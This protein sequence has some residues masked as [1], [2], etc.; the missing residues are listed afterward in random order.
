MLNRRLYSTRD[1]RHQE[2]YCCRWTRV[3]CDQTG[4]VT[5]LDL[6]FVG[7]CTNELNANSF[8]SSISSSLIYLL[9]LE[10]LDLRYN[11]FSV[12]IPSFIG[13]LT[14]FVLFTLIL[15]RQIF[16][17]RFQMNFEI[18]PR[19]IILISAPI[20]LIRVPF[21]ILLLPSPC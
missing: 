18:S 2:E 7:P 1:R 17:E 20:S 19:L 10:Y 11:R 6:A 12:P 4:H 9:L 5:H 15:D 3:E 16:K 8:H 13:S 21:Q 14:N